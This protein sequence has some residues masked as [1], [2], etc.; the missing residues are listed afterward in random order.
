[1]LN[2]TVF[3]SL[4]VVDSLQSQIAYSVQSSIG[5]GLF[6]FSTAVFRISEWVLCMCVCVWVFFQYTITNKMVML[7][8]WLWLEILWLKSV[9][10]PASLHSGYFTQTIFL[11]RLFL[12]L[13]GH[14]FVFCKI[15]SMLSGFSNH[16]VDV[17]RSKIFQFDLG[18]TTAVTYNRKV[19]RH[20]LGFVYY[21]L[22][23]GC[24]FQCSLF[25]CL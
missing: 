25:V 6:N 7:R 5:K 18:W 24:F 17:V 12:K 9:T 20:P 22:H 8:L 11:L 16:V 14:S 21:L 13:P 2:P 1:M 4:P 15:K 10:H 19:V 3:D 23:G